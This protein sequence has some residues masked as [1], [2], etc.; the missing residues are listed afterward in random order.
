VDTT[1]WQRQWLDF[2]RQPNR[3]RLLNLL[4]H[5]PWAGIEN[6]LPWT[7]RIDARDELHRRYSRGLI[8]AQMRQWLAQWI[9]D[10]YAIVDNVV[11][12]ADLDEFNAFLDE[13]TECERPFEGLRI[14]GVL[15][16]DGGPQVD[17][18]HAQLLQRPKAERRLILARGLWRIS[19]AHLFCPA[20]KRLLENAPL[21]RLANA[22]LGPEGRPFSTL[23]F[24]YGSQQEAHQDMAVFSIY[25]HNNLVG[26]WI[27]C[28]DVSPD[29]GPF[30]VYPGSHRELLYE[31]FVD[32]PQTSLRTADEALR[33]RYSDEYIP[34]LTKRYRQVE[35][36]A[37]KGQVLLWHSMLLHG[38]VPVRNPALTRRSLVLH[39]DVPSANH[40][41]SVLGPYNF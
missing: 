10:G 16:V 30:F 4:G 25:P 37:K 34:V 3:G 24:K 20:A 31:E 21:L 14:L 22:I 19:G 38:G 26:A 39:Y 17:L 11:D 33:R 2:V 28:E 40:A 27:A 13:L 36:I 15:L 6:V 29:C 23:S 18:T 7:D 41:H 35:F 8:D 32:Y 1:L 9:D 5:P 12:H